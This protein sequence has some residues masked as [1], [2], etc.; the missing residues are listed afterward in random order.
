MED[1]PRHSWTHR[2]PME[3]PL[4]RGEETMLVNSLLFEEQPVRSVKSVDV[5]A[6][7]GFIAGAVMTVLVL[8][9]L[10]GM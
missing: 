10:T 6:L 5:A 4:T 3:E 9:F 7:I 1:L 8:G 2:G